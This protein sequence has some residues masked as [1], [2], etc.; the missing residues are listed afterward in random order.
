MQLVSA[1]SPVR[2]KTSSKTRSEDLSQHT[3]N[4]QTTYCVELCPIAKHDLVLLPKKLA[5]SLGAPR[6]AVCSHTTGQLHFVDPK[7]G[8]KFEL[9]RDRY[10]QS[11]FLPWETS[12]SLTDFVVLDIEEPERRGGKDSALCGARDV[13]VAR[14]RDF[15]INDVTF[16]V[17]SHL[18]DQL[19]VGDH[20]K[21][22]DI[23]SANVRTCI[24][25]SLDSADMPEVVLVRPTEGDKAHA[26]I[27]N[28]DSIQP[29]RLDLKRLV[30]E[31]D[32][33]KKGKA[34]AREFDAFA[35]DWADEQLAT[36][37]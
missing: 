27:G 20:V 7:S 31:S 30:D 6:I 36:A 14:V 37:A 19:E 33:S 15:G 25:Y 3:A 10:W 13:E 2:I 23:A 21:G 8:K 24:A 32:G 12:A 22:Y 11:E 35:A 4:I 28:G 29:A 18:A 34:E 1:L 17:R 9:S 26:G 16:F 5:Q